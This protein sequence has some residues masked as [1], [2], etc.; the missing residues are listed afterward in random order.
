MKKR[1]VIAFL[2][3]IGVLCQADT[4]KH[5][6]KDITHHGYVTSQV[7][8]GK[9]VIMTE[10]GPVE[11][12][13]SDY[14]IEFNATGRTNQ[15]SVLRIA[16]PIALEHSTKAFEQA[17]VEEADKGPLL[18]IVEIDTPG[19]RVDLCK[20]LC[21]AISN[22]RHCKVI[23]YICGGEHAG[24]YSAGAAISLSCDEI[25]MVPEVSIG[26][27]TMIMTGASGKT[28]DMKEVYG[29][30]VGEKYNSAWRSYLASLAEQTNRSGALAKA[31]A[32]KDIVV[33]EIERDGKTLFIESQHK[34]N[35]D[36]I[37]RTVCKK[38]E[39]LTLS[40]KEAVNLKIAS[41]IAESRLNLLTAAGIAEDTPIIEST[42][43]VESKE[44]FEKVVRK[45]KKLNERVDLKFKE[46]QA[47]AKGG[48]LTRA[49][50]LRDYRAIIKNGEYLL[51]LKRTYP[52]IPFSEEMLVQFV[53]N[54]KAEYAGIK[55]M[56]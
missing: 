12:N 38:G 8:N 35:T 32:D 3:V 14:T 40:A 19:G 53:N 13:L 16:E 10:Q 6:Q 21:A 29:D 52:D 15:V 56:R 24:A 30:S 55:S 36:Q 45:F 17:I 46:L 20:R 5:K 7:N 39:L 54:V 51:K 23:G 33:I 50:A 42:K 2:M 31:M 4:F 9:H 22:I 26:A 1:I 41:G 49:Q 28:K 34:E 47:R 48:S 37:V 27:A 44:E 25:Y 18:I 43:M 11:L